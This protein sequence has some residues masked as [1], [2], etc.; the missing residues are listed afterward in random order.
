ML[1]S[2]FVM[3]LQSIVFV[4]VLNGLT[5]TSKELNG[6]KYME[7]QL[8]QTVYVLQGL[9]SFTGFKTFILEKF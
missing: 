7:V 8:H 1:I 9:I 6:K 4:K 5:G 3:C 2:Y